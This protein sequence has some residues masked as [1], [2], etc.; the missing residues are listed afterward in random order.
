MN[1]IITSPQSS[2]AD[3]HCHAL[4]AEI[5]H[6]TLES[7]HDLYKHFVPIPAYYIGST[8]IK[9][10][11]HLYHSVLARSIWQYWQRGFSASFPLPFSIQRILPQDAPFL[12]T[13]DD[14]VADYDSWS[15]HSWYLQC[16]DGKMVGQN[17]LH[18]LKFFISV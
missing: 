8:L 13:S 9:V 2:D 1:S 14:T 12:Q 6:S 3:V 18:N 16:Q 15:R 7:V 17:E 10:D 4:T 5:S 11:S